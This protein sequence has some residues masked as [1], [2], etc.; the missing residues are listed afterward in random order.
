MRE[1]GRGKTI[2]SLHKVMA[3]FLFSYCVKISCLMLLH[4]FTT[5]K[6]MLFFDERVKLSEEVIAL[7]CDNHTSSIVLS[8]N[9]IILYKKIYWTSIHL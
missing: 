1:G 2:L 7:R 5:F 3:I 9:V 6:H 4:N 8:Y